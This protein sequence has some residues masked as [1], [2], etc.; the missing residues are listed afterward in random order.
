MWLLCFCIG[1]IV[2]MRLMDFISIYIFD[3]HGCDFMVLLCE[4]F[5]YVVGCKCLCDV[6]L[7]CCVFLDMI[8]HYVMVVCFLYDVVDVPI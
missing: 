6:L 1:Y 7:H 8:M 4:S 5:Y 3:A 2:D